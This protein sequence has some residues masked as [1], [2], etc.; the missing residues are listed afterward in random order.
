[1][2]R[3]RL[4]SVDV[5]EIDDDIIDLIANEPR[6]MPYFH[7]SLQ[8]GS[9]AVLKRMRRRHTYSDVEKFC[10]KVLQL[11]PESAFGADIITGFPGETEEEFLQSV[12]IV[13]N[14]PITFIHAFPFLV[15]RK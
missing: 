4:S 9:D 13:K 12:K 14:A 1:M 6:F 15:V 3:L 11:R 7:I 5:A 10:H 8:S 2:K